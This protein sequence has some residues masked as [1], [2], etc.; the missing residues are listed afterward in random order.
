MVANFG[1]AGNF[2]QDDAVV[3]GSIA[4]AAGS[5]FARR[6]AAPLNYEMGLPDCSDVRP[7]ADWPGPGTVYAT[8]LEE[9][10]QRTFLRHWLRALLRP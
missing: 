6:T 8:G 10:V 9:G 7:I 3:W 1:P 4:R 2:G 5:V